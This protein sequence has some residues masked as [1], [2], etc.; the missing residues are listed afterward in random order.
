MRARTV[1][2]WAF[3]SS[4]LTCAR[5]CDSSSSRRPTRSFSWSM[6][7]EEEEEEDEEDA[8]AAEEEDEEEEDEEEAA[9]GAACA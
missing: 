9:A 2:G 3:A 8:A 1:S 4:E 7:P 6:S 5:M